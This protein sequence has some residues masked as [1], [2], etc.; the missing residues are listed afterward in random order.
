MGFFQIFIIALALSLDAAGVA[1]S[2]GLNCEVKT[3]N[4]AYFCIS[5]CF[6]Q[7]LFSFLGGYGGLIFSTHV[8]A[9]PNIIGGI[10]IAVVG[11]MM[12]RE[13]MESKEECILLKPKM[14]VILGIS[15]SIDA[16]V[17]GFTALNNLSMAL[18]LNYSVFIG[19]VTL[20]L[21]IIA[22]ILSRFLHRI[23][24]VVK[25]ADYIGGIILVIFGL[26]MIFF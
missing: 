6:F 24:F 8:A 19:I 14:Y 10:I 22:F 2:I 18:L 11:I 5:F 12:I 9:I 1:L 21:C 15:V 3:L 17:V 4:K 23:Q 25:Y 20:G 7:F 13:G 26:K 16:L